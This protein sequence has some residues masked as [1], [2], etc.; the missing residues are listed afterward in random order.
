MY[1]T[2]AC[3]KQM[4]NA[5]PDHTETNKVLAHVFFEGLEYIARSLL[6][7]A[8]GGESLSMTSEK[9]YD[10]LDKLSEGNQGCKGD[11]S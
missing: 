4:L 6:H 7:S 9:F 5:C 2:L 1:Q 3:F 10:L 11:T 8:A